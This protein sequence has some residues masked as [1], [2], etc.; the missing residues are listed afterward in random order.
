MRPRLV[1]YCSAS[2]L[3]MKFAPSKAALGCGACELTPTE[4]KNSA[5]GSSAQKSMAA[6]DNCTLTVSDGP[7]LA[8]VLLLHGGEIALA[9][10]R[11]EQA[12]VHVILHPLAAAGELRQDVRGARLGDFDVGR[13]LRLEVVVGDVEDFQI[14]DLEFLGQ[15]VFRARRVAEREIVAFDRSLQESGEHIAPARDVASPHHDRAEHPWNLLGYEI[16]E[17]VD[18]LLARQAR[19]R[20][21]KRRGFDLARLHRAEAARAAAIFLQRHG[22]ARE[23]EPR[24]R[25]RNGG[26][27]L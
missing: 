27:A 10:E 9:L 13:R 7:R 11:R 15:D 3:S 17:N 18:A 25:Q 20:L 8:P 4:P 23:A 1:R 2:R 14:G 26:I 16:D 5:T 24:Q 22:A 19:E 12:R 6:Q 21:V